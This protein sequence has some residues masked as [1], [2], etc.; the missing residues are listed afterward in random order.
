MESLVN[1]IAAIG[2]EEGPLV[3]RYPL[4]GKQKLR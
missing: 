3:R 2:I 4:P 1:A